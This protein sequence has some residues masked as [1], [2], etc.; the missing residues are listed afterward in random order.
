MRLLG[1]GDLPLDD[2]AKKAIRENLALTAKAIYHYEMMLLIPDDERLT[3]LTD[4]LQVS[5]KSGQKVGYLIEYGNRCSQYNN[6]IKEMSL[7]LNN[8]THHGEALKM[9]NTPTIYLKMGFKQLP[10]L[11]SQKHLRNSMKSKGRFKSNHHTHGLPERL[12]RKIP[13]LLND[14]VL[15]YN[16]PANPNRI[17]VVLNGVDMDGY[18]LFA[19]IEPNATDL[20]MHKG[21]QVVAANVVRTVFGKDNLIAHLEH[22]VPASEVIYFDKEKSQDLERLAGI[23]FPRY[24]SSL[25]FNMIIQQPRCIC[26]SK[27]PQHCDMEAEPAKKALEKGSVKEVSRKEAT[28]IDQIGDAIVEE[29]PHSPAVLQKDGDGIDGR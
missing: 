7:C 6:Y 27:V 4:N 16:S 9:S 13:E 18:P 14:P 19:A 29:R 1:W 15:V 22:K 2:K 12:A 10:L 24:Y 20:N 3:Y 28:G 23:Q 8:K 11:Y 26:N 21:K 5:F 17:C 25:S